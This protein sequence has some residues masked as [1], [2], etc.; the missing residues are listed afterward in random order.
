M[1]MIMPTSEAGFVTGAC[2]TIDE[3]EHRKSKNKNKISK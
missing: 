3:G 2:L 1:K